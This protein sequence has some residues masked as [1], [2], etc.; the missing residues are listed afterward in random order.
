MTIGEANKMYRVCPT[1]DMVFFVG[2]NMAQ[3]SA[4]DRPVSEQKQLPVLVLLRVDP[5]LCIMVNLP[6]ALGTGTSCVSPSPSLRCKAV[7][8]WV[9]ESTG[10]E[11]WFV[12]RL[13]AAAI[14]TAA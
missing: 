10:A 3:A 5:S 6:R 9:S 1:E 2:H 11:S 13:E 7:N 8:W 12:A 14:L 4:R